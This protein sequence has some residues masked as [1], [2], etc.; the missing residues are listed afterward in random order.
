[1]ST[2]S[3]VVKNTGFLYFRMVVTMIISLWTTRI[4]LNALGAENF[5]IYNVVGGA[6]ALLGFL[7]AA[8]AGATQRFL[9]V[10]EGNNSILK[11]TEVFN[12]AIF[13]HL[14][15]GISSGLLLIVAGFIFFDGVLDIPATRMFAAKVVYAVM[16]I[17]TV[18][19]IISVPYDALINAH[20][21]MK[22]Y[23][24]IGIFETVM[25]LVIAYSIVIFNTD[26]LIL[27]AVMMCFVP[28]CSLTAMRIYCHKNYLECVMNLR[29]YVN[30]KLVK[31]MV[32]FTGWNLVNTTSS[33]TTQ[34]G[35]NIIINH[36]F[37]VILN[38]A[39]GIATQVSGVILGL[40]QNAMKAL[41]PII[42]KS[43]GV[44]DNSRMNYVSMLGCRMT[45][46]IFGFIGFPLI[47]FMPIILK[48][49]LV[50]VPAWAVIFCQLQ[51]VRLLTEMVT[52]GLSTSIQANGKVKWYYINKA[53]VN[54]I[55]LLIIPIIF[56]LGYP[57]YW[58]YVIWI[59]CWSVIGGCVNLYYSQK[60]NG[61]VL[62]EFLNTVGVPILIVSILPCLC[63]GLGVLFQ[64]E[65]LFIPIMS[66]LIY[67]V[68]YVYLFWK[69]VLN[70]EE[71]ES[72]ALLINKIIVRR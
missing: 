3:R 53:I 35:L 57:P 63:L 59:F 21:N 19:T 45:F 48:L 49:W 7:N 60:L 36:F 39:Q 22:W 71:R 32:S 27:Y 40:S 16:I 13:L 31:E 33:M 52:F 18:F 30:R 37:G 8:M 1:M 43:G 44:N 65:T 15:I 10:G 72:M 2:S 55:P 23:A 20:E 50:N 17:S 28:V 9:N 26:K 67:V 56:A 69:S 61:L 47:F 66:I 12:S 29:K 42:F 70:K 25:K 14:I 6:I 64:G 46:S 5:G 58:M 68:F 54:C 51:I 24:I 41:N 62:S 38:A 4:I 11:Q 34:Y